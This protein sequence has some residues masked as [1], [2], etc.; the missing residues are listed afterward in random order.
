MVRV[1]PIKPLQNLGGRF[2]W[3]LFYSAQELRENLNSQQHFLPYILNVQFEPDW[4]LTFHVLY[5]ERVWDDT[6]PS[7]YISTEGRSDPTAKLRGRSEIEIGNGF[8][9]RYGYEGSSSEKRWR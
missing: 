7:Y 6:G 2:R 8:A 5:D 4:W 3:G 9:R 1:G